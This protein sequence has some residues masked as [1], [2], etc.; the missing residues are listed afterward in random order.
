VSL[1]F[2]TSPVVLGLLAPIAFVLEFDRMTKR[3]SMDGAEDDLFSEASL[4]T[5]GFVSGTGLLKL[6]LLGCCNAV[7]YNW[8]HNKVIAMTSATTTTVLGNAKVAMLVLF[9]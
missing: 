3:L 7:V 4:A 8:V 6:V 1:T 9:R 5:P 2:Y